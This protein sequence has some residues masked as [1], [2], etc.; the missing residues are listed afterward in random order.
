MKVTYE[1]F[2]GDKKIA[3]LSNAKMNSDHLLVLR[4]KKTPLQGFF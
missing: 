3:N 2:W 4:R 1:G